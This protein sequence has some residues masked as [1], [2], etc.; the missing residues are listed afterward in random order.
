MLSLCGL[1]TAIAADGSGPEKKLVDSANELGQEGDRLQKEGRYDEALARY[2]V[3]I[4]LN[5][6]FA[7]GYAARGQT[8]IY[9]DRA[10]EALASFRRAVALQPNAPYLYDSLTYVYLI[11]GRDEAIEAAK[12]GLKRGGWKTKGVSM[13]TIIALNLALRRAG[14]IEEARQILDEAAGR[15]NTDEWPFPI[16]DYVRGKLAANDLVELGNKNKNQYEVQ[17]FFGMDLA[18]SGR[19]DDA[20]RYLQWVVEQ[21]GLNWETA[22]ARSELRRIAYLESMPAWPETETKRLSILMLVAD[23]DAD[24]G[25]SFEIDAELMARLLGRQ[26]DPTRIGAHLI[27]RQ[28]ET[29]FTREEIKGAIRKLEVKETDAFLCFIAGRSHSERKPVQDLLLPGGTVL[30][31][32]ELLDALVAKG[33]R[34]TVLVTDWSNAGTRPGHEVVPLSAPGLEPRILYRLLFGYTGVVD[35]ASCSANEISFCLVDEMGAVG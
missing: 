10:D 23:D 27:L 17:A 28:S 31:R 14:R 6:E 13:Y 22:L 26:I 30:G 33:A 8:L 29:K 5:P 11:L 4:R 15:C 12:S 7:A 1:R 24:F 34:L 3:A 21:K 35:I 20:K 9:A 32:S 19:K 25:A 18:L 16:I 2:G